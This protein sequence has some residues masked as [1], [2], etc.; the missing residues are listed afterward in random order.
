MFEFW[1]GASDLPVYHFLIRA[2]IVYIYIFIL[3]KILGQRSI[4]TFDPLD[5]IFGIIIGDIVGEPL[6]AGDVPLPGPLAAAAFIAGIHLFLSWIALKLPRFRRVIEDEPLVLVKNGQIIHKELNRMKIT[7]ESLMM[8]LRLQNAIDLTEVDYAV[9]E[10]N[11]KISVIKKTMYDTASP[12][13]IGK[14]PESK[15]Y[16]T[17]LISDGRVIDANLKKVKSRS[18]LQEQLIKHG[19]KEP[20]ECFLLTLDEAE[21]VYVSKRLSKEEQNHILGNSQ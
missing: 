16:P 13:D 3:L 17:V 1:Q 9:L 7:V 20:K 15:G 10:P 21:N 6:A 14:A 8:D 2:I 5:F 4:G 12:A 19:L 18:W 11:G